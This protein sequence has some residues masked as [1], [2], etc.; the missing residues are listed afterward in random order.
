M[1]DVFI[2]H[3]S[4]DKEAIARPLADALSKA[5]FK[6]WYDDLTL[7]LGDSLSR[8]INRGLSESRYGIVILSP[9]FLHK[10]WPQRELDGLTTRE[11]SSGKIILP[12]W[13]N[14]TRTDVERYSPILADKLSV[15]T[16]QGLDVVVSEI[17]HVLREEPSAIRIQPRPKRRTWKTIG[18]IAG[19][20]IAIV[21][22]GQLYRY[23]QRQQPETARTQ[24]GQMSLPYT[25][26]AFIESAKNDDAHAVELYLKAGMDP[27]AKD[28]HGNTALMYATAEE[29]SQI[30]EAL[31]KAHANVNE[32][33]SNGGTALDW[34]A[35]Y[36]NEKSL[37]MLL[38]NGAQA[39]AINNAFLTAARMG[40]I[41][42]ARMLLDA[43]AN[44]EAV[45]PKA[46][47]LAADPNSQGVTDQSQNDMVALLIQLGV[48][49][50][51]KNEYGW[52]P[53]HLAA[54]RGYLAV[55]QSL[56]DA[57]AEVNG[58]CECHGFLEGGWTALLM[59]VRQRH[60]KIVET[61]LAHGADVNAKDN[62]G[63]TALMMAAD[64]GDADQ[65]QA[66]LEA[67]ARLEEKDRQG[68]TALSYAEHSGHAAIQQLLQHRQSP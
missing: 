34:A 43:G 2:S 3:A 33:N 31:I 64:A 63:Q 68:R 23:V 19:L 55:V 46:L 1:W 59:A 49:V 25:A 10:E 47:I 48:D 21:L 4:E 54:N 8:S 26:E 61:M 56:I 36:G 57:G 11:V 53:L 9:A 58:I 52:T 35:A 13:H 40:E 20:F 14:V 41:T 18:V 66:L 29:R 16:D 22:G 65:V 30:M 67:G 7:K 27:N 45:G 5:G 38:A 60:G 28:S 32:Q 62:R 17:I 51:T 12:V 15:S 37:A 24:L 50:N 42:I 39:E 6:V 44:V